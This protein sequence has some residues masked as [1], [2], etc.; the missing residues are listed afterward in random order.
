MNSDVSASDPC[1]IYYDGDYPSK[2]FSQYPENFDE[3]TKYQGLHGDA[4]RYL[5]LFKEFGGPVL[6]LCCGTGRIAIPLAKA[7]ADITCV[8]IAESML[9]R[10]AKNIERTDQTLN[11]KIEL[12]HQDVTQL[13]LGRQDYRLA[14]IPFNSLLCIPTFK[15]Q[16]DIRAK[17]A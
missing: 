16:M 8:D 14:L 17:K 7:G 15:G 13:G 11:Q 2:Y 6:E 9:S 10:F 5:E 1:V 3:I 12:V 4:D